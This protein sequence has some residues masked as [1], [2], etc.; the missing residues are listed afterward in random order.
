MATRAVEEAVSPG[1]LRLESRPWPVR[2][3]RGFLWFAWHKPL[4]LLGVVII[5]LMVSFA[6]AAALDL[7]ARASHVR[8]GPLGF[9]Y[10]YDYQVLRDRQQGPSARHL[11]G[12][13][14]LGRDTFS[15]VV[16]GAKVSVVIG[17]AAVAI[18]QGLAAAIGIVSGY[19]GGRFDVIFQRVVDI[20]QAL[21]GLVALIF[22]VSVLGNSMVVLTLALGSLSAAAA[23]RVI[24]GAVL[25]L[26]ESPYIDAARVIGASDLRILVLHI[27]PNVFHLVIINAS[28]GIGAAILAESSLAF[29]GFGLPPPYPTWGRML[30]SA[31]EFLTSN[32]MLAIWPGVALTLTVFA[33]NVL[34]DALRDVLDPRLR[35]SR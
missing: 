22:I 10:P 24:R 4:G 25:A 7:P 12:T 15:R 14:N 34:G 19:Y 26:K 8:G 11:M 18:A 27:L 32:P 28:I 20:W 9:V 21:P 31:R 13:D 17:F 16:Y 35:S 23:S 30:N 6:V 29:L 3:L 5:F 2:A 1:A 33:F